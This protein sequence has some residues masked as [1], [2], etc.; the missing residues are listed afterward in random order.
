[1]GRNNFKKALKHIESRSVDNNIARLNDELKKT[2]MLSEKM[3]TSTVLPPTETQPYIPPTISD[4]PDSSGL[5]GNSFSQPTNGGDEDD[6]STWQNGWPNNDYLKNPNDLSGETDRPILAQVNA[7]YPY[8]DGGGTSTIVFGS[9]AFGTSVGVISS[10]NIYRQ[11]LV[12]GLIGGTNRPTESSRGSG[13]VYRSLTD[14]QFNYAVALYEKYSELNDKRLAGELE[15]GV[16]KVW[17][18]YSRFHDGGGS[19]EEYTGVKKST[20]ERPQLILIGIQYFKEA[21]T[22]TSDPG[23]ART[24]VLNRLEDPDS[25][26]YYEGDFTRYLRNL[27]DLSGRAFDYLD[28]KA[29]ETENLIAGFGPRPDGTTGWNSPGDVNTGHDGTLYKLV[30]RPGYGY[31][32]WVPLKKASAGEGDTEVAQG[33]PPGGPNPYGT[34]GADDPFDNDYYKGPPPDLDDDSDF[35]DPFPDLPL[36]SGDWPRANPGKAP[37]PIYDPMNP[38]MPRRP[39]SG[40]RP[41]NPPIGPQPKY[42]LAKKGGKK[43]KQSVVAHHEP[44]GDVLSEGWQSPDHTNVEKD[45]KTR[46]FSPNAGTDSAKWF[47]P[48]EVK[49]IYPEEPPRMIDGYNAK[50]NLAPKFV[51]K[52]PAIKL[53]K[54]DLLR[55]HRLKDSEIEEMMRTINRIN[56]FIADHPEELIYAKS[57]YPKHDP[58]LA[59]LNWKMDQMLNASNEYLDKQFPENER[60]FNRLKVATQKT[61]ELTDPETYKKDPGK[62]TSMGNLAKVDSVMNHYVPKDRVVSKIK[63]EKKKSVNRFFVKP[64]RPDRPAYLRKKKKGKPNS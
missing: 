58:R 23:Q 30:P 36:A 33:Y 51:E 28:Q 10:D 45:P 41:F 2:G 52:P 15:T 42:P 55:N 11:I 37:P 22:Y 56:K 63:V 48:K 61:I 8:D 39:G 7:T 20:E 5:L 13:G 27:L 43:K 21:N 64:K 24:T 17:K 32:I 46:W 12:G 4:V 1:M 49:P 18:D 25:P 60:L 44:Q 57:R 40:G 54:K 50:S 19:F 62:L 3:T 35:E 16:L 53:T 14:E 59:E 9:I 34:P 29:L 38:G 31:N 47:D 6:S 26:D